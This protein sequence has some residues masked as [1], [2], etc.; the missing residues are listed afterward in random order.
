ME[1]SARQPSGEPR[2]NSQWQSGQYM[3]EYVTSSKHLSFTY[4]GT[5]DDACQEKV[6]AWSDV[7]HAS[8]DDDVTL[9][10]YIGD[11]GQYGNPWSVKCE[12]NLAA[13]RVTYWVL[14]LVNST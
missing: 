14:T 13:S 11:V 1:R 6:Y 10:L 5:V 9:W 4:A 12:N 2:S 8:T 3:F 7:R